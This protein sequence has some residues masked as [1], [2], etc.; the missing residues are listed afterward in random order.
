[1]KSEEAGIVGIKKILIIV[2]TTLVVYLGFKYLLPLIL[3]FVVAYF[4]AWII[5][6]VTEFL[7]KRLKISRLVGGTFS[8]LVL[9]VI[10]SIG[11]F[12]LI[13][14]LLKQVIY[15][16]KNM[17]IYL[18]LLT[19]KLELVCHNCDDLFGLSSGTIRTIVDDNI[20]L[21]MN[22]IKSN[23]M[24]SITQH[25][26]SLII[27]IIGVIGIILIIFI[28]ALLIVKDR[29]YYKERYE[30]SNFYQD[31]HKVTEKLTEA[32]IAY[33]RSQVIIMTI[34]AVVCVLGLSILKN[35]YALLLGLGIALMDALP[36][37]GSGIIFIPWS[38]I[39]L[40]NGNIYHAAI[41][42]T[43]Y[44][45]CQVVREVLEP[46]LIGNRIGIKPI[47]TLMSMYA[48]LKLFSIAGFVLGPVGLIIIISIVKVVNEKIEDS[49]AKA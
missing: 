23:I 47:F 25:S 49:I 17:P 3:P 18:N 48:G 27:A 41:L 42:I 24:P 14:T 39:M 10:T 15:L 29:P 32:G 8:L 4:L 2:L 1:M 19:D 43:I 26:I 36:I 35:E 31:I 30:N 22:R 13:N 16:I 21:T 7:Y 45:I 37:I 28:A 20:E 40:L 46:R 33:L 5:R 11:I 6:P 9:I 34:V 44:L 12:F 38:I